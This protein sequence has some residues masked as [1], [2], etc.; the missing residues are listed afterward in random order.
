M[1][2]DLVSRKVDAIVASGSSSA[3]LAAPGTDRR[4]VTCHRRRPAGCR[5][6]GPDVPGDARPCGRV[7]S[8]TSH[9]L[10]QQ[11]AFELMTSRKVA[12]W[13]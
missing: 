1:A 9:R 5:H 2:A 6:T 4:A 12:S 7:S 11:T 13:H 8:R 3:A 10:T